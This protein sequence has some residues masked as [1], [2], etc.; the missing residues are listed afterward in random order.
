MRDRSKFVAAS[1]SI[2]TEVITDKHKFNLS[3]AI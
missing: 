2:N 3:E 1:G